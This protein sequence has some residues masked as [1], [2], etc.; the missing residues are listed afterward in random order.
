MLRLSPNGIL[1]LGSKTTLLEKR[2]SARTKAREEMVEL[3][4]RM[5]AIEN[6]ETP[7]S[8]EW[9]QNLTDQRFNSRKLQALLSHPSHYPYRPY[10]IPTLSQAPVRPIQNIANPPS[11]NDPVKEAQ[12]EI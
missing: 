2:T 1:P 5:H 7:R 11:M 6:A 3:E 10:P 9:L 12:I 4:K 8:P